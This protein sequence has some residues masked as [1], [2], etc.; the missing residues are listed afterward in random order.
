MISS[1]SIL[2]FLHWSTTYLELYIKPPMRMI[3]T[4]KTRLVK[5]FMAV[6]IFSPSTF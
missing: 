4:R 1:G 5:I 6:L 3:R 2:G